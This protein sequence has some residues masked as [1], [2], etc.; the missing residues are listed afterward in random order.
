[1][2]KKLCF[3]LLALCACCVLNSCDPYVED[4][5]SY[6]FYVWR[7]ESVHTIT[8]SL[9]VD[10]PFQSPSGKELNFTLVP[11]GEYD[12]M[13]GGNTPPGD[14]RYNWRMTV[15]FDDGTY[16]AEFDYGVE[17]PLNY[18]ADFDPTLKE[19][20]EYEEVENPY[21]CRL[22][23]GHR[24]TYTFTDADYEAAVAYGERARRCNRITF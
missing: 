1:M 14:Y 13:R 5:A 19:N 16:G 3:T 24:W 20:Y 2:K 17:K 4:G 23:S 18:N 9:V 8:L 10:D 12:A 11:G 21:D 22:C 7:N 6:S 15:L